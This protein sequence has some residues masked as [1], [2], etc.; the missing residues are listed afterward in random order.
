MVGRVGAINRDA[1]VWTVPAKRTKPN[2]RHRVPLCTPRCSNLNTDIAPGRVIVHYM[3]TQRPHGPPLIQF[4][5]HLDELER[6][7]VRA[8]ELVVVTG[9]RSRG[10]VG[11]NHSQ[12][13]VTND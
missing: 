2:R 7:T 13:F 12:L 6:V 3:K 5:E 4:P 11:L 8:R 10:E 9:W 1:G